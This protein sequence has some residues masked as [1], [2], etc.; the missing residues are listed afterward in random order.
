MQ[1]YKKNSIHFKGNIL[2]QLQFG[3]FFLLLIGVTLLLLKHNAVDFRGYIFNVE[4]CS[5]TE[6]MLDPGFMSGLARNYRDKNINY[7]FK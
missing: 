6:N 4:C 1:F 5:H 3:V 2:L 7:H